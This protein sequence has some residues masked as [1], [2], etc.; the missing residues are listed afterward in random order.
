VDVICSEAVALLAQSVGST[1][2]AVHKAQ[3][4]ALCMHLL[5]AASNRSDAHFCRGSRFAVAAALLFSQ[6][7]AL[8]AARPALAQIAESSC[9][10]WF[11]AKSGT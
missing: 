8:H 2:T 3:G 11:A 6:G 10:S 5:P 1:H 9:Q 7:K 4:K